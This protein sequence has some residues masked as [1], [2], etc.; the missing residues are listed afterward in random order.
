[1]SANR[2]VSI[3]DVLV[4]EWVDG[5]GTRTR[6][7]VMIHKGGYYKP[8]SRMIES[9]PLGLRELADIAK[10]AIAAGGKVVAITSN[11][12]VRAFWNHD[13]SLDT[14]VASVYG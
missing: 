4:I 11:Y 1:M 6:K 12:D 9:L 2:P 13:G 14:E 10:D 8:R 3:V 7:A 5:N